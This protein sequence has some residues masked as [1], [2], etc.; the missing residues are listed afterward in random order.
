M[1]L[2]KEQFFSSSKKATEH[3]IPELGGSVFIKPMT[4]KQRVEYEDAIHPFIEKDTNAS[5]LRMMALTVIHAIC[6]K[7]KNNI[8]L[9]KLV[10]RS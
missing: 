7:D 2:T 10:F 1:A 9:V 3:N 4:A 6:D 5:A 8:F